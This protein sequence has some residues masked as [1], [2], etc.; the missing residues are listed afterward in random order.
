MMFGLDSSVA[1]V[2]GID[3]DCTIH[4]RT[5]MPMRYY[6]PVIWQA[7]PGGAPSA[8]DSGAVPIMLSKGGH[9]GL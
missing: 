5:D 6:P 9:L 1:G 3:D 7:M 2:A 4:S 8:A